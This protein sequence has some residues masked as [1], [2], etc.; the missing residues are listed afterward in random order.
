MSP[1]LRVGGGLAGLLLTASVSFGYTWIHPVTRQPI[2]P[3]P[4]ATGPG[5][6]AVGPEGMVYGPNYYLQPPWQPFNGHLPGATGQAI[7]AARCGGPW[8]G[9]Q[10]GG[11]P[12]GYPP[13][14]LPQPPQAPPAARPMPYPSHP[15][16]R[17]PRDFFMWN[18]MLD[19]QNGRDLRPNLVP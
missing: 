18:E 3:A 16:I 7:M 13:G 19:E 11:G 4:D 8:N 2:M 9:M 17:G 10:Q 15:F 5:W 12:G 1:L 14:M 6:Y